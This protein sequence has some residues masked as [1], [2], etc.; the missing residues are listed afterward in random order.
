M[1]LRRQ[2]PLRRDRD[3][4]RQQYISSLRF[5]ELSESSEKLEVRESEITGIKFAI[6]RYGI[7]AL[8]ICYASNESSD[9]L[10]D[11]RAGWIG[12]M[13]GSDITSLRI[14]C[15]VRLYT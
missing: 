11:P 5:N 12:V 6:G 10:G 15:D 2:D 8:R 1:P 9:W 4:I 7:K 3:N 13:H 14:L